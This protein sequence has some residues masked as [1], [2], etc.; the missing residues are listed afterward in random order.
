M[1]ASFKIPIFTS[2]VV[3]YSHTF[4]VEKLLVTLHDGP[5]VCQLLLTNYVGL[6]RYVPKH[7]PVFLKTV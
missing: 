7:F 3:L 2:I 5:R 1:A 6:V 4:F